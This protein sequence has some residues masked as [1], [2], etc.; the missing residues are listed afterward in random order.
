MNNKRVSVLLP[1]G[2]S[3]VAEASNDPSYPYEL[4]VGILGNDGVWYQDLA[5]VRN[6][7]HYED[8]N[9][10]VYGPVYDED[11]YE[12]LVFGNENDED[13]TESFE[14]GHHHGGI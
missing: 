4:Y 11:K 6:A 7:Y 9:K 14:I 12:V 13:Y 8:D 10:T 1:N 3:L 5:V 2:F